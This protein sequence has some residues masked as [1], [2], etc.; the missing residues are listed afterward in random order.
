MID[1]L[2]DRLDEY[3]PA[4]LA[5]QEAAIGT[6]ALGTTSGEGLLIMR[7]EH[8]GLRLGMQG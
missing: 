1:R 7:L 8:R 6:S 4:W 2:D 5:A 3:A